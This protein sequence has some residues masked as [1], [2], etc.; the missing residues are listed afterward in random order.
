M[1]NLDHPTC[2]HSKSQPS[3]S[4]ESNLDN[5]ELVDPVSGRRFQP[6]FT[7]R[8]SEV[9][10]MEVYFPAEGRP[11]GMHAHPSQDEFYYVRS[12]TLTVRTDFSLRSYPQGQ[13]V[14][15][16]R[17]RFHS[18]WNQGELPA[19]ATWITSPGLRSLKLLHCFLKL[20]AKGRTDDSGSAVGMF[21]IWLSLRFFDVYRS[22]YSLSRL[23]CAVFARL[24]M[25]LGSKGI[26]GKKVGS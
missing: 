11:P 16:K 4:G 7:G 6:I 9:L 17:G 25:L 15:I 22:R 13:M 2:H 23:R 3:L 24:S 10:E 12:G 18:V 26:F 19:S 14:H 8:P 21:E 5:Q 1:E 20:A